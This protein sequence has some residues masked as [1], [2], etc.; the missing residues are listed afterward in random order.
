[1]LSMQLSRFDQQMP[2]DG[3]DI[4]FL[5]NSVLAGYVALDAGVT[6]ADYM[7]INSE[8][9]E[10]IRYD[11]V[12]PELDGYQL[13]VMIDNYAAEPYDLWCSIEYAERA[14]TR[15]LTTEEIDKC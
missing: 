14:L 3:Q 10:S 6:T 11:P 7:W 9:S 2:E 15:A 13:A 5:K 8:T 4:I 1:M 12:E